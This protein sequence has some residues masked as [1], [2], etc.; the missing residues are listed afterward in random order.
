MNDLDQHIRRELDRVIGAA[1]PPVPVETILTRGGP[2]TGRRPRPSR[3]LAL[4]VPA[5]AAIAAVLAVVLIAGDERG[6]GPAV[7][8][9]ATEPVEGAAVGRPVTNEPPETTVVV[10]QA[11]RWLGETVPDLAVQLPDVTERELWA[12]LAERDPRPP[13][14][15]RVA[16]LADIDV[17][18]LTGS[19]LPWEG[20]L[21]AGTHS[22]DAG[23]DA[24]DVVAELYGELERMAADFGYDRSVERLG[25]SP[26][27]VVI[28]ASLVETADPVD[29]D[30]RA[31]IARVLHN[32]LAEGLPIG[33]D[34]AYRY[35]AQDRELEIT[36]AVLE[37]P[38]PYALR[39]T[40]GLPP[41]PI[42]TPSRAS[43]RAAV[44]PTPGPW[45]FY[46]VG[47]DDGGYRF[48]TTLDEFQA[49][50]AAARDRGLLD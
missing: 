39:T 13:F 42:A 30:D 46:V 16:D 43:L 6:A 49:D 1:P 7:D 25:L 47:D 3:P 15:P 38:G 19:Q 32:R 23:S 10:V 29:D 50:V 35:A 24:A 36:A 20:L 4:A 28:I 17:P 11:G 26:Y 14:A 41:T 12:A 44:E 22:I 34:A 5:L 45:L 18:G 31:R 27:E 48:S 40:P 2:P 9:E 21:A 33:I 37:A 8:V